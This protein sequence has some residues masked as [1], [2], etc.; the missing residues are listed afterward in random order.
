M[1]F[2]TPTGSSSEIFPAGG[3][4]AF[5]SIA[6]TAVYPTGGSAEN[7]RTPAIMQFFENGPF[8]GTGVQARTLHAHGTEVEGGTINFDVALRGGGLFDL[9][10]AEKRGTEFTVRLGT[11]S[12]ALTLDGCLMESLTFSA[13]SRSVVSGTIVFKSPNRWTS[14]GA[15]SVVRAAPVSYFASG[16]NGVEDWSLTVTQPLTPVFPNDE[17][18]PLPKYLRVGKTQGT[19]TATTFGGLKKSA[20]ISIG[21]GLVTVI[22]VVTQQALQLASRGRA[23]N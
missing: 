11:R 13:A 15:I 6:G 14:G 9:L 18:D 19:L 8:P 5:A 12:Q 2:F 20:T 22:G 21:V 1:T 7:A 23:N 3:H 10:D 17:N 4:V 16:S